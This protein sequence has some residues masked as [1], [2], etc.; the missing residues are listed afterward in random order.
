MHVHNNIVGFA[1]HAVKQLYDS[2]ALRNTL[3]VGQAVL[4]R[5]STSSICTSVILPHPAKETDSQLA[6]APSGRG[7]GDIPDL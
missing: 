1:A 5:C 2:L 6:V 7:F 4:A 3:E